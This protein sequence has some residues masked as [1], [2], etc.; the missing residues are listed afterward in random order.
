MKHSLG[1]ANGNPSSIHYTNAYP[2]FHAPARFAKSLST[3]QPLDKLL[4]IR[5]IRGINSFVKRR[6]ATM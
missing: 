6:P 3:F 5:L 1:I 2:S 4:H